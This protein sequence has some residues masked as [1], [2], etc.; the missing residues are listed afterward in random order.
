MP[1]LPVKYPD[2]NGIRT[3]WASLEFS[4]LGIKLK[5][6]KSLDFKEA[7]P[8]PKIYGTSSTPIGRTKG[9]VDPSGSIEFYQHEFQILLPILSRGGVYG[10]AENGSLL[11]ASWSELLSPEQTFMATLVGARVHEPDSSGS[12]GAEA[13]TVKCSLSLMGIIWGKGHQSIRARPF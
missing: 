3:S 5:G 11:T 10:F 12:E 7:H 2:I 1:P 6:V 9:N 8:I 13:S 4:V